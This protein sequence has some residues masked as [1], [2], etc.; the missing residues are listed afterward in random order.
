[1]AA[2]IHYGMASTDGV[3]HVTAIALQKTGGFVPAAPT[4]WGSRL[5]P[6]PA[7]RLAALG[8]CRDL[9][10]DARLPS[11]WARR[12]TLSGFEHLARMRA[13]PNMRVCSVRPTPWRRRRAGS[14]RYDAQGPAP[15]CC[16]TAQK[17]ARRYARDAVATRCAEGA[18]ELSAAPTAAPRDGCRPGSEVRFAWAAQAVC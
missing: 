16:V 11:A 4:S 7:I 18:Y 3:G 12:Q 15:T 9:C 13:L 6:A 17:H 10:D 8:G 2:V 1:M 5:C 14:S